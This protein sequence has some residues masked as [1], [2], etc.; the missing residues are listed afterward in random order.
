MA[1]YFYSVA[2]YCTF[3]FLNLCESMLFCMSACQVK[4]L[5]ETSMETKPNFPKEM[6]PADTHMFSCSH[7]YAC[8]SR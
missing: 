5:V 2:Q 1:Q 6:P 4:F 7:E 3:T 8:T